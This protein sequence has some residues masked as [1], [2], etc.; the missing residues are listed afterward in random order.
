MKPLLTCFLFCLI[1]CTTREEKI[2]KEKNNINDRIK[3]LVVLNDTLFR[4]TFKQIDNIAITGKYDSSGLS[5]RNRMEHE[6]NH[7]IDSLEKVLDSLETE[8]KKY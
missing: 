3:T 6:N 7:E 2:L 1:S 8:L 4:S 5:E